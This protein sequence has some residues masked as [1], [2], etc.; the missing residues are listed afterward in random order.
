MRIRV[1]IMTMIIA[2]TFGFF[3]GCGSDSD[4]VSPPNPPD[5]TIVDPDGGTFSFVSGA[6]ILT[7]PEDAV[8]DSVTIDVE[9][10]DIYPADDGFVPGTCFAFSPDGQQFLTP[11]TMKISYDESNLP[12][13]VEESSLKL[14]KIVG[15]TWQIVS[16]YSVNA[17]SNYVSAPVSG[18]SSYGI[19]GTVSGGG[20]VFEGDY[21]VTDSTSM[22]A[23]Q[24]YTAITG[25]LEIRSDA[26][27]T[28]VI[29]N[30]VSI[31]GQ[32][33]LYGPSAI[34]HNVLTVSLPSLETV[35]YMLKIEN[36]D[37]L[38]SFSMPSIVSVGSFVVER[39]TS[40]KDLN[41]ISTLSTLNP[42]SHNYYGSIYISQN[43]SLESIV[44]LSGVSGTAMGLT[45][46]YNN[47]LASLAG[48]SGISHTTSD[49][50]IQNCLLLTS[51]TGLNVRSVGGHAIVRNCGGLQDLNGFENL[52]TVSRNLQIENCTGLTDLT[53]LGMVTSVGGFFLEDL[54][55][56]E[57]LDGLAPISSIGGTLSIIDCEE[58]T[59]ISDLEYV[60][61]ITYNLQVEYCDAVTQIGSTVYLNYLPYLDNVDPLAQ[62]DFI[63]GSLIIS[64]CWRLNSVA[65]LW[66]LLPNPTTGYVLEYLYII[67]N[68][69]AVVPSGLT[70]AKAWE[71]VEKI[72]GESKIHYTITIEGN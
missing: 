40:L 17:E 58:L 62:C 20:N 7:V 4:P 53:G 11:I 12:A 27:D 13:N 69:Q 19:V 38:T 70:N 6:V 68:N 34:S 47:K 63:G 29:P 25:D 49:L 30:L 18:F 26:P 15:D 56:L 14:C 66:G 50:T 51:L 5:G 24:E 52:Q 43:D 57:S 65:G 61:S 60:T 32:L 59:D 42:N 36:C 22:L 23:F 54:S 46:Q 9:A 72:G 35:E 37:S 8:D 10:E 3:F 41:G 2:G 21:Y 44:G 55:S 16:G 45:I 64:N 71:L 28:V 48:L 67:E 33:H 31:G 39:N 1:F